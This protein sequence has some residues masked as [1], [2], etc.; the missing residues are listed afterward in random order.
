[1]QRASDE[2]RQRDAQVEREEADASEHREADPEPRHGRHV[3]EPLAHFASGARLGRLPRELAFAHQ[4][5]ARDHREVRHCIE[6][7]APAEADTRDERTGQ[8]GTRDLRQGDDRA[9]EHDGVR[10]IVLRDHLGHERAAKWVV[11]RQEHAAREGQRVEQRERRVRL[12]REHRQRDRLSH[13]QALREQQRA[14][15]VHAIGQRAR[16]CREHDQ[17]PELARR[18]CA[19]GQAAVS[20][21]EHEQDQRHVGELIAGVRDQLANEK[22]PKIA[23]RERLEGLAERRARASHGRG[24]R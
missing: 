20:E 18:E 23:G 13:L 7:E 6:G 12:E 21:L 3:G 4:D 8:R 1:M 19:H 5:Q 14:P 2:Q 17:G 10:Q 22:E 11:E 24:R 16:P 15:L 9:V